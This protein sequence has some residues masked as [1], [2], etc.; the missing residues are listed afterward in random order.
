L[1]A[2]VDAERQSKRIYP[3]PNV[4]PFLWFLSF[5]YQAVFAAFDFTPLN[6]VKAVILGQDPYF[7]P[8]Q[9]EGLCFSVNKGIPIPP[10]LKRIYAVCRV[11]LFVCLFVLP[12]LFFLFFI[13]Y[14]LARRLRLSSLD[15]VPLITA[16]SKAGRRMESCCSTPCMIFGKNSIFYYSCFV[17]LFCVIVNW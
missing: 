4:R 10:S 9:A 6:S 11:W 5:N 15:G 14:S 2:F 7:N 3:P 1:V 8:G 12:L 16:A 17:Y 13:P